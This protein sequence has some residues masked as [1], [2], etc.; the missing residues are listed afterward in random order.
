MKIVDDRTSHL[1]M[2]RELKDGKVFFYKGNFYIKV[3]EHS[4]NNQTSVNLE[5]GDVLVSSD[6]ILVQPLEA[7]LYVSEVSTTN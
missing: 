7:E 2:V 5:N 4:K 6:D 3:N 1:V